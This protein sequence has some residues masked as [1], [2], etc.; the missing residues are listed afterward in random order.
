M[1]APRQHEFSGFTVRG[2]ADAL[3]A[4]KLKE[5]VWPRLGPAAREAMD[6]P[7]RFKFHLGAAIDEVVIAVVDVHG[8]DAAAAMMEHATRASIEGV[9]A[10]LARMYLTLKGNDPHVLFERFND[11]SRATSRG[12]ESRWTRE[13]PTRG[14]LELRYV[15]APDQRVGHPWRGA[16][17]FVLEFC[18]KS[19]EP[20]LEPVGDDPRVVALTIEWK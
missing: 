5:A 9:V 2:I 15:S 14:R 1:A 11:L 17:R 8:P 16:L 13:G 18:G 12:I 4:L 6:H 19:G 7:T 10:P 20:V 3:V